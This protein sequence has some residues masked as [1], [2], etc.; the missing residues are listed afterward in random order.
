VPVRRDDNSGKRGGND[1]KVGKRACT[2]GGSI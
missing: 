1:L 2:V